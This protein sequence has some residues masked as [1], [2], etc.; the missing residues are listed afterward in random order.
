MR[1]IKNYKCKT[2]KVNENISNVI[3]NRI[4]KQKKSLLFIF[5][6]TVLSFAFTFISCSDK[7]ED[8]VINDNP[9]ANKLTEKL[10]GSW[11][12]EKDRE[13]Y[14]FYS[15][16]MVRWN[17]FTNS[18]TEIAE[19]RYSIKK[20][21]TYQ[22][23][24]YEITFED[25]GYG[26][27]GH[28]ELEF[29]TNNKIKLG[30]KYF[31]RDGEYSGNDEN[32]GGKTVD[33]QKIVNENVTADVKYEYYTFSLELYTYLTDPGKY[34]A[35]RSDINYGIEW[36]YTNRPESSYY[37]ILD[38]ENR[39]MDVSKV[40]SNHYSVIIPVFAWDDDSEK[41]TLLNL[42]SFQYR[43]AKKAEERGETLTKDEKDLVYSL[44]KKLN[45]Y[46]NEVNA[47]RGKVYVEIDSKRYYIK[48]FSK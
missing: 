28:F 11:L 8:I 34:Y 1:F 25:C 30:S 6:F 33:I 39:F 24:Y 44:E 26:S 10:I 22:R 20:G 35:G 19:F 7:K 23:E 14:T 18:S 46:I 47:Y 27:G 2:I 5:I 37:Y 38:S 43:A 15:N 21:Q 17:L 48:S 4:M 29:I 12:D 31:Y 16:G 41:T 42:Y 45:N 9:I 36:Y 3:N 13:Q 32:S 40:S